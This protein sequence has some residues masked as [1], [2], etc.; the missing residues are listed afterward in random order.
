MSLKIFTHLVFVMLIAVGCANVTPTPLPAPTRDIAPGVPASTRAPVSNSPTAVLDVAKFGTLS[1]SGGNVTLDAQ[2]ID[3]QI[4]RPIIFAV[5]MNT[6]SVDLADDMTKLATLRDDAGKEY[7][8]LA[9]AGAG[10]GGHHREG[11]LKFAGLTSK[12]RYIELVVRGLAKVPE[13]VL[14]WELR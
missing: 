13:R 14:R 8:P 2:L 1:H 12:P 7:A 6:H 10:P 11:Q 4:D 3:F 9:W 5:A